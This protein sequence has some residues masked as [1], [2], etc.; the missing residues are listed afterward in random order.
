MYHTGYIW[1]L[2]SFWH[3]KN[4]EFSG[5]GEVPKHPLNNFSDFFFGKNSNFCEFKEDYTSRF[6][7]QFENKI[8]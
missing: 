3:W 8:L 2:I 1:K 6:S 4:T 7:K 5:E